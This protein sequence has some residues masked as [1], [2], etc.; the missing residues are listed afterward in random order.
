MK[1]MP[2]LMDLVPIEEE[3]IAEQESIAK[4]PELST[5]LLVAGA[6]CMAVAL[7]TVVIKNNKK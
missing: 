4:L 5:I 7:V 1:F 3:I 2:V 6:V